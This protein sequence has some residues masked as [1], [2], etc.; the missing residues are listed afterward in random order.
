[1][2]AG[3]YKLPF[4][5]GVSQQHTS[6]GAGSTVF[7]GCSRTDDTPRGS[8][9]VGPTFVEHRWNTR[10]TC[11]KK[12]LEPGRADA[13]AAHP[14]AAVPQHVQRERRVEQ[15]VDEQRLRVEQSSR[16][17]GTRGSARAPP[18]RRS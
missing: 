14:W 13:G 16:R 4:C 17:R 18:P 9:S 7:H 5:A 10:G 15:R 11:Y 2:C 1:M 8:T 6:G 3:G 12:S